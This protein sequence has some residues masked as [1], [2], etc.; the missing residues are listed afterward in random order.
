MNAQD[1]EISELLELASIESLEAQ[2]ERN[3]FLWALEQAE[4]ARI[5]GRHYSNQS[6]NP[7]D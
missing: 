2:E 5:E 7:H 3:D 6:L 4:E 1:P